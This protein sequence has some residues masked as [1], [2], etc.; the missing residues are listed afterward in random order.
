MDPMRTPPSGS[1]GFGS[2]PATPPY[3]PGGYPPVPVTVPP[4]V[5]VVDPV[6]EFMRGNIHP[7]VLPLR[8]EDV[9]A[10]FDG[11]RQLA[12]SWCWREVVRLCE[13]CILNT[14]NLPHQRIQWRYAQAFALARM[15]LPNDAADVLERHVLR[16]TPEQNR[17]ETYA[18]L[19]PNKKGTMVNFALRFLYARLPLLKQETQQAQTRLYELLHHC[20]QQGLE[21]SAEGQPRS[22]PGSGPPTLEEGLALDGADTVSVWGARERR[23]K[24]EL[25]ATH[26]ALHQHICALEILNDVLAEY[27]PEM[28]RNTPNG[29]LEYMDLLQRLG[30]LHLDAGQTGPADDAFS[31]VEAIDESILSE[32][33]AAMWQTAQAINRGTLSMAQQQYGRGFEEFAS[34]LAKDPNNIEAANNQAICALYNC[35]LT[36]AISILEDLIRRDPKQAL[37]EAV[38]FNL[39]SMY[40]LQSEQGA[41]KK[42]VLQSVVQRYKGDF[43][44]VKY[45]RLD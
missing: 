27:T 3:T 33:E 24:L 1:F 34:V 32:S 7:P 18:N 9:P 21:G 12:G 16:F 45:L 26:A 38:I 5:E 8:A 11:L 37:T 17:Y 35:H 22:T 23:V 10:S 29:Q 13:H 40:D 4:V 31:R 44:P 30:N 41:S 36:E 15:N 2:A 20:R 25:V 14:P 39:C 28:R 6:A 42:K 19:Y 43:F